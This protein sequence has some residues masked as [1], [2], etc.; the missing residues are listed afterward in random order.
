MPIR[1]CSNNIEYF[2]APSLA[3]YHRTKPLLSSPAGVRVRWLACIIRTSN[4]R[5][6]S[7][8]SFPQHFPANSNSKLCNAARRPTS[9]IWRTRYEYI[10]EGERAQG[11]TNKTP[12]EGNIHAS[13]D[14]RGAS[15]NSGIERRVFIRLPASESSYSDYTYTRAGVLSCT[16]ATPILVSRFGSRKIQKRPNNFREYA[17]RSRAPGEYA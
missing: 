3:Q 13:G 5:L 8:F 17:E 16:R 15:L 12:R 4:A 1:Q 14:T 11:L 6:S 10:G 7:K 9:S 2:G